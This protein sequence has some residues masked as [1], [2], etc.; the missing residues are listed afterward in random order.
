MLAVD[1]RPAVERF[2]DL[3]DLAVAVLAERRRIEAEHQVELQSPRARAAARAM[4]I[5]QFCRREL[6]AAARAALVIQVEEDDAVLHE[7]PVECCI[8]VLMRG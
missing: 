2:A 4:P 8:V 3:E 1:E 6:V 5:H 7:V